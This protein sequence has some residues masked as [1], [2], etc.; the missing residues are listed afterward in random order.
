[1]LETLQD[2]TDAFLFTY[3][4]CLIYNIVSISYTSVGHVL[5]VLLHFFHKWKNTAKLY[6]LDLLKKLCD[7]L[8]E[9]SLFILS[10]ADGSHELYSKVKEFELKLNALS[11][12][13]Q[14]QLRVL[15]WSVST[16][17]HA[18]SYYWSDN[19]IIRY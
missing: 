14:T 16:L 12:V 15:G 4:L 19:C 17:K 8:P 18:A 3:E 7:L 5:N 2:G 1:M 10:T 13:G 11:L 6:K 9:A